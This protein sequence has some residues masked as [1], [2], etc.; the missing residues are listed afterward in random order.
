[1]ESQPAVVPLNPPPLSASSSKNN[2]PASS[3]SV[4]PRQRKQKKGLH[5]IEED[6]EDTLNK[7]IPPAAESE[8]PSVK[9]QIS[10]SKF[11][12]KKDAPIVVPDDNFVMVEVTSSKTKPPKQGN[13]TDSDEVD[14]DV[15]NE[16]R[17]TVVHVEG[18]MR[19][20]ALEECIPLSKKERL[21]RL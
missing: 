7:V 17:N 4:K 21:A 14:E 16:A 8:V 13:E 19:K 1:M 10:K 5:I 15:V 20:S 6:E 11:A 2:H 3:E 12:F 9:S 18:E